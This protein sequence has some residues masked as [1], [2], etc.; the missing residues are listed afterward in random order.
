M[1]RRVSLRFRLTVAF[2]VGMAVILAALGGFLY[3]RMGAALLQSI[4]LDLRARAELTLAPLRSNG[5]LPIGAGHKL[6]DPDEA[7][8]QVLSPSGRI[9]DTTAAVARAPMIDAAT[10]ASISKPTFLTRM[11]SGVDDPARLL[12]V[13]VRLDRTPLLVAIG[14][15]LGDR[16]QALSNLVLFLSIGGPLALALSSCAGWVLAGAAL[17][18]VERM[19]REAAAIS[20][21]DV[22]ARLAVPATN[23][24]AHLAETLND[25]LG[26]LQEALQRE[27]RFVDDASHE[28]RTPLATLKAELE[29]A[30]ARPRGVE[31]LEATVRA[32]LSQTDRLVR[33]AEDLLVLARATG[34]RLPV[35]RVEV[36]LK[37]LLE[38][39]ASPFRTRTRSPRG[40][41]VV[42][43]PDQPVRVD[44]D[45][46]RQAVQNLLDNAI[47]YGGSS[48]IRI[49]GIREDGTVRIEV[50]DRGPGFSAGL[51]DGTVFEPFVRGPSGDGQGHAGLGLSI[52]RAVAAAH[53]GR[54]T[55]AN[56]EGGGARVEFTVRDPG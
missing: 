21:S 29:L 6:I 18:P 43:A 47:R 23:E 17:R 39:A 4:D 38:E 9:V 53:G 49:A 48:P 42:E 8:A 34:G 31:E 24:L 27:H 3:L 11:V 2:G 35:R 55:A 28:L 13:P 19:R 5:P 36:S 52:V 45:R 16:N 10:A 40:S 14:A 25:L 54:A 50:E 41:L 30:V 12:V 46:I 56:L 33:L 32:A 26:R 7:F 20:E 1:S 15:P 44:P 22:E 51:L 37:E